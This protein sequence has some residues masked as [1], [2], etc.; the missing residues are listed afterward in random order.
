MP[1]GAEDLWVQSLGW[2]VR[3]HFTGPSSPR[4]WGRG[5][6]RSR[7]QLL[8]S[9]VSAVSHTDLIAQDDGWWALEKAVGHS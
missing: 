7:G 2:E 4:E 8:E 5:S 1:P 9:G 3:R 6:R